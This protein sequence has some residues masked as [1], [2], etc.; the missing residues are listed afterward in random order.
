[1]NHRVGWF[2]KK[3]STAYTVNHQVLTITLASKL[4][5]PKPQLN[6]I[7]PTKSVGLHLGKPRIGSLL[8][9]FAIEIYTYTR[10]CPPKYTLV[11]NPI[12][13]TIIPR[14]IGEKQLL[15]I[16]NFWHHRVISC[17]D[18]VI[19]VMIPLYTCVYIYI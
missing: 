8:L 6:G 4:P 18:I 15:A 19:S 17:V 12:V 13:V 14:E 9:S 11:Y 7:N 2:I 10:W 16:P 1:M 5:L 3:H